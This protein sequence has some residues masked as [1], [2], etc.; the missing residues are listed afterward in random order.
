MNTLD[1]DRKT[2]T[3]DSADAVE[4]L[5]HI[6]HAMLAAERMMR[7]AERMQWQHFQ[8][9]MREHVGIVN[10]RFDR[11]PYLELEIVRFQLP[12]LQRLE[13]LYEQVERRAGEAVTDAKAAIDYR[14][15][16]LS[17][18]EVRVAEEIGRAQ[19][20]L[21]QSLDEQR[22]RHAGVTHYVWSA[23]GDERTRAG[24][25][26]QDGETYSWAEGSPIGHPGEPPNCRCSA[27]PVEVDVEKEPQFEEFDVAVLGG[28]RIIIQQILK[29]AGDKLVQLPKPRTS[30]PKPPEK[31]KPPRGKRAP[32]GGRTDTKW[33]L[34]KH[35][36]KQKWKNQMK[37]RGWNGKQITEAIKKGRAFPVENKMTGGAATR[38]VHPRTGRSIVR[39]NKTKEI[40]QV[41]GDGFNF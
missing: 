7:E 39:D 22:Q 29:R 8:Q 36:T 41:G 4:A 19:Q 20:R 9:Q 14:D 28:I 16:L 40:L 13:Q 18:I 32:V 26:A 12:L 5:K 27:I 11:E 3:P 34:G 24:H 30:T 2:V 15:P 25:L 37:D 6:Y 10:I 1:L 17:Q 23:V 38:Y 21:S 35:K 33:K 31:S